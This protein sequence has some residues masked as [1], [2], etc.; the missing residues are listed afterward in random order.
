MI[1]NL[2]V[3]MLDLDIII[4]NFLAKLILVPHTLLYIC[5][6]VY[7]LASTTHSGCFVIFKLFLLNCYFLTEI[8]SKIESFNRIINFCV[9]NHGF[10]FTQKSR[11]IM[12]PTEI[13]LIKIL[14]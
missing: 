1:A 13:Y 8:Q 2:T 14:L 10:R 6:Y 3:I 11:N 7:V 4:Y 9:P 12:R 5:W